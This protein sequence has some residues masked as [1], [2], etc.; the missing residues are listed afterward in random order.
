MQTL[1]AIV[2]AIF[3]IFVVVLLHECGHFLVARWC[4]VKVERFSIGFGRAIWRFFDRRGTEYRIAWIPLGGYVKMFGD[5][6]Q[7]V[8]P[9]DK[10]F[11]FNAKPIWQR[12]LIVAAGPVTNFLLAIILFCV[13][14]C[15]GVMQI[16]PVIGTITPQSIAAVAALKPGQQIIGVGDQQTLSWEDVYFALLAKVGESGELPVVVKPLTGGA[17]VT[18][19]L[20]LDTWQVNLEKP[21]LIG[22]LGIKPYF[23]PIPAK[24]KR[25]LG[26]SP[27]A[28]VGLK[29]NDL[30]VAV[31][32]HPMK[33]W[34]NV[35]N[36]IRQ[37]ADK[38]VNITVKRNGV[39]QTYVVN[40]AQ[41]DH[42]GFLGVEVYP[43]KLVNNLVHRHRYR[44][45]QALWKATEQTYKLVVL[46][47]IILKKMIMGNISLKALGGPISVLQTAG[48]ASQ[49]GWIIYLSFMAFIS[50][51]LGFL[52]LLPIPLLDG[53]HLLFYVIE[54]VRGGRPLSERA[55]TLM[56]RLGI[57]VL[58]FIMVQAT[59]NDLMR[60][61]S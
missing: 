43:P 26:G 42:H 37:D 51:A 31:N 28:K 8:A 11:A 41:S 19:Y 32:D 47:I 50:V 21:D 34:Q 52:N 6:R 61:F 9:A 49:Q 5:D 44:P 33:D 14:Y 58:L 60:L 17:A 18:H 55:Q 30:I 24:I 7:V 29:P 46:N 2:G 16:K 25:V 13:V 15:Y 59:I 57:L 4:G 27:A 36:A 22:S 3:V 10:P 12:V 23:P 45:D 54:G 48:Q 20:N 56:L 1:I 35:V 38:K 53:G 39:T 40:I